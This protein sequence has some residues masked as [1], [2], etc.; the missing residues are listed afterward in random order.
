MYRSDKFLIFGHRGAPHF[1]PENTVVSFK[2]AIE[3]GVNSIE[4]D[5]LLTNDGQVVVFHDYDLERLGGRCDK[6]IDLNY[7]EIKNIDISHNWSDVYGFQKIPLLID[8]IQLLK[9]Y[10]IILNI[11][12]KSTGILSTKIVEIV[13]S[14]IVEN[15][16]EDNCIVSSFNPFIIREIKKI[17]PNLFTSLIWSKSEVPFIQKFYKL[18]YFIAKPNGFH[19][20]KN[21]IDAEIVGWAKLKR[22]YI[23]VF[24]VN[25]VKDWKDMEKFNIN[26][27]FTDNPRIAISK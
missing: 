17:N 10:D 25:S 27:V 20:D 14:I 2:K 22:M 5:V 6:I 26:G 11:E 18:S 8:I 23:Y 3:M 16:F 13:N 9:H 12:I 21:F 1:A 15:N 24:T 4:L 19:I 7:N